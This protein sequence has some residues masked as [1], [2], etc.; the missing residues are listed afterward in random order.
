MPL[1]L[2]AVLLSLLPG[3]PA[4]LR[5][6]QYAKLDGL[7][8]GHMIVGGLAGTQRLPMQLYLKTKGRRVEGRSYVQ[9]PDGTTLRMDLLGSFF[10]DGSIELR[11]VA[12]AGDSTN[13]LMPEFNRQYQIL[14]SD[15]IWNP[16]LNGY[17]QEVTKDVF[18]KGRRLG[19]M[20]LARRNADGA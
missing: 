19:R 6:T 11:E 1:L 5:D 15:D 7:W 9:L 2:F 3:S 17:W 14:L 13:E 4:D 8:E 18:K 16:V 10:R 12:F 20:E